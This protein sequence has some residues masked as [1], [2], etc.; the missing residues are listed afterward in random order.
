MARLILALP[1][2]LRPDALFP[3]LPAAAPGLDKLLRRGDPLVPAPSLTGLACRFLGLPDEAAPPV[4]ALTALGDGLEGTSGY[5]LRL[6]PGY[7]E[8]GMGGLMF[9]PASRLDLGLEEARAL[10]DS[11]RPYWE[12]SG[13]GGRLLVPA[14]GRWYVTLDTDPDLV[15][16]P[17]DRIGA[18][19]L[20]P[21]LPRGRGAMAW[22]RRVN[23]AQMVLHDH[24]VNRAREAAGRAPINGLWLWGGGRCPALPAQPGTLLGGDEDNLA[25]ARGAG[26]RADPLPDTADGIG[27]AR[28]LAVLPSLD[29]G[30]T[31][32]DTLADLD[33][34]WFAP[35][36]AA[37]R[38][39]RRAE[40]ELHLAD[41]AVRLTPASAWRL[42]R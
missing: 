5:W 31:L 35:L 12:E 14:A 10:A 37:L 4:A 19:Y 42:W 16:T 6:D 7:L 36:L 40:L 39:G 34:R 25:L 15:T 33:R 2:A 26:A 18:D 23:E 30:H 3:T 28:T 22:M 27:D 8:P 17:L 29:D 1:S 21:H 20:T 32:A 38:L 11:L 24:P 13:A 41:R 9:T